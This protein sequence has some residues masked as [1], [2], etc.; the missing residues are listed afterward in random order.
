MYGYEP[1][2]ALGGP[3]TLDTVRRVPL[4]AHHAFLASLQPAQLVR[5]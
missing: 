3:G 1:A 4:A 2:L 5:F